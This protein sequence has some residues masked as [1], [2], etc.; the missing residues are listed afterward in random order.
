MS[1][2]TF[3]E[4]KADAFADRM[5]GV[6]NDGALALMLSIGHRTGLFDMLVK[7]KA[8]S[9][10]QLAEAAGLNERYVREWLG[11]MTVAGVVDYD[12]E[13]RTY[14]LPG[15]HAAFLTRAASPNNFAAFIQYVAV[16]GAV[17][18]DVVA[19]FSHGQ[20]VPYSA[21]KRF[22]AVMAEDSAQTTVGALS[23]HILPLI[24]GLV[25]RLESGIDVLDV[26]CGSGLALMRM[27]TLFPKSRF[28][29]LDIS[30]ETISDAHTEV[31]RRGLG[32]L[33]FEVSDVASLPLEQAYDLVTAFDAIHDQA[34][35]DR[36]LSNICTALRPDGIFL[37]QDIAGSSHLE[38]NLDHPLGTFLY[39][40]SCMHCMSVSLA[41][42]GPGL[43]AM[44]GKEKALEMLDEAGFKD[45]KVEQLAHDFQN[46][47]YIVRKEPVAE[48]RK[49]VLG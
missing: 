39:T 46:Y 10:D 16:L 27:A 5:V 20:G 1:V 23:E 31:K 8:V 6:F 43:G 33:A 40:I 30:E 14:H 47:Y 35:P 3:D 4:T 2:S 41:A 24:P 26:G 17:E 22:H 32:N 37:M 29:G 44:W 18:D 9:S 21:Y 45:V 34:K 13:K 42:G 19:A 36:V 7:H 38:K 25:G 49:D 12:P 28:T 11:T 48:D 15:E